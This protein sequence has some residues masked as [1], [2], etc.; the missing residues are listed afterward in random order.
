M[1]PSPYR[2]IVINGYG[3]REAVVAD[4]AIDVLGNFAECKF[5]GMSSNDH[6]AKAGI[7]TVP[8]LDERRSADPINAG[9]FPYVD[10]YDL[11]AQCLS[12]KR[13]RVYPSLCFQDWYFA[14]GSGDTGNCGDPQEQSNEKGSR[15][16][17]GK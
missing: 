4:T 14:G 2:V 10:Q 1:Q 13:R 3:I 16:G 11:A 7:V 12:V 5:G 17:T 15:Y 8:S 6:Q 9:V